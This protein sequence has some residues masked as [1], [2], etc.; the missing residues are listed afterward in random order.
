MTDPTHNPPKAMSGLMDRYKGLT[1]GK[2]LNKRQ[3]ML[4]LFCDR[5]PSLPASTVCSLMSHIE[6]DDLHAIYTKFDREA[7][8]FTALWKWHFMPKKK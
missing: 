6:T 4:K 7:K 2:T 5:I 1:V 3:A 8:N